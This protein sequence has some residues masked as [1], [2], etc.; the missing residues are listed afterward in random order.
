MKE[1]EF[2]K[3]IYKSI[4]KKNK[5]FEQTR[6]GLFSSIIDLNEP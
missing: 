3:I 1:K 5:K 2:E 6:V 4:D